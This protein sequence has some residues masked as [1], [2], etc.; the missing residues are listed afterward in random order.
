MDII[1]SLWWWEIDDIE[2]NKE[3]KDIDDVNIFWE[4]YVVGKFVGNNNNDDEVEI[5][6]I[7]EEL[8]V[9]EVKIFED[10]GN[11]DILSKKNLTYVNLLEIIVNE[12]RLK[13]LLYLEN[14]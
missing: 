5:A 1:F 2:I 3:S 13:L 11:V 9:V 7:F 10:S 14:N 12:M 6:A 8:L 4:K